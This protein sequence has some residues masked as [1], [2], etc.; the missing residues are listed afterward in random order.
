MFSTY[1]ELHDFSLALKGMLLVTQNN[2]WYFTKNV[3]NF[4]TEQCVQDYKALWANEIKTPFR[5][6]KNKV[7]KV[8]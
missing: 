3:L 1:D 4:T 6:Y 2:R 7:K 5:D 8:Q